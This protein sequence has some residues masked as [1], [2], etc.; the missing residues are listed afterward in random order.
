MS[1]NSKGSPFL[2]LFTAVAIVAAVSLLPL[3]KISRGLLRDFNLAGDIM[4]ITEKSDLDAEKVETQQIDP[5]LIAA[6]EE[7]DVEQPAQADEY[8]IEK[9]DTITR[10]SESEPEQPKSENVQP[11]KSPVTS[12][13][14]EPPVP[15]DPH[16]GEIIVMEDYSP[17]GNGLKRF[18]SAL[19]Q[20]GN[21][22]V[23][24][25]ILGDSYIEGDIFTQDVREKLQDQYGGCGVGYVNMYSEFPGFRR[26]ITQ[27]GSGWEVYN[28]SMKGHNKAYI[29]ITQQYSMPVSEKATATYKGA[30]RLKHTDS[31]EKSRFIYISPDAATINTRQDNGEWT[32]HS[33]SASSEAQCIEVTGPMKSFSVS[34]GN[35]SLAGIG[36]WLDGNNGI[37]VD[38]MS[39]RGFSGV[40]LSRVSSSLSQSMRRYIDYDLI[41]IEYGIN[42]MSEAQTDYSAYSKLM[43][44]SIGHIKECYPNADII[45]MGVG[46]RG[47]KRGTDIIT[48]PTTY[49]MIAAQRDV[50]RHL[51]CVFWDTREAMGGENA[52]VTWAN[53]NPPKAN[54]DYIHLTHIGGR[55]LAEEFLKSLNNAIN[56]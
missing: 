32:S 41:V 53:A 39:S 37:S 16:D 1:K 27:S 43:I 28:V 18:K 20:A 49:N 35:M 4:H 19:A 42:A 44:K 47:S 21:R 12:E 55:K 6:M 25:A 30:K 31:W 54:K 29:S 9:S 45:I 33:S 24:I 2:I 11:E 7:I 22:V 26:S 14:V 8:A 17:D 52:I 38:C 34:T 36:V 50:A 51:G 23:R 10:Q 13:A 56:K 5:E 48:M 40:T 3:N 15:I 46:D